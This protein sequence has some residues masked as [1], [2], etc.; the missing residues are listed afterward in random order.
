MAIHC[1]LQF[2]Q[3]PDK[4]SIAAQS[5]STGWELYIFLTVNA[6]M[7][8]PFLH[9]LWYGAVMGE[10]LICNNKKAYHDYFIEDKFEAGL[11]LQGTEVKSLRAG[12]A[13]L[14]DSFMLVREGEAYLHNLTI[15]QYEFGNRQNHQTDR[16][17]KLLL[18]RREIEKLYSRMREKGLSV[19]PLRLYFKNG[20]VKV[21]IGLAKGKKLYDKREDM[22]TKDSNRELAQALKSRNRD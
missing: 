1:L 5:R 16:N 8:I 18:H 15:S 10:K 9:N 3:H 13:N 17:R 19:I 21:E 2:T 12:M 7:T 4:R 22:K 20:L 14:N 11:V 6:R